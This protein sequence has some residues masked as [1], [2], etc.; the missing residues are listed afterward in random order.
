MGKHALT[1]GCVMCTCVYYLCQEEIVIGNSQMKIF[2]PVLGLVS[3]VPN[4]ITASLDIDISNIF[5]LKEHG[6]IAI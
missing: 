1:I 4:H 5:F 6:F 2:S 3:F